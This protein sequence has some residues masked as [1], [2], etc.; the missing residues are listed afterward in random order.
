MC[1]AVEGTPSPGLYAAGSPSPSGHAGS[2][3]PYTG[4]PGLAEP[5]QPLE[6]LQLPL[7]SPQAVHSAQAG[8]SHTADRTMVG[9]ASSET[10]T[11]LQATLKGGKRG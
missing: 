3:V 1:W 2:A 5:L 7:G 11:P 4:V 6:P 9:S 8:P 10:P